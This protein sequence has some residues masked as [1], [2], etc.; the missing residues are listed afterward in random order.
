MVN[1]AL[2]LHNTDMALETIEV[3]VYL[4]SVKKKIN[5]F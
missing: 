4:D 2:K 5:G 3:K 1:L